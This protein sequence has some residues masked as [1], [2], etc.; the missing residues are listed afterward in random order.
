[1][2][3]SYSFF[4][5]LLGIAFLVVASIYEKMLALPLARFLGAA[6]KWI[7]GHAKTR[8]K[9]KVIQEELRKAGAF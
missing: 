7:T 9:Y 2:S 3:T 8:K 1:M 4:V 6:I 5:V